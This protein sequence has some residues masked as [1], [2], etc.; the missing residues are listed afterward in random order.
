MQRFFPS[1]SPS[2]FVIFL[3]RLKLMYSP[4]KWTGLKCSTQSFIFIQKRERERVNLKSTGVHYSLLQICFKLYQQQEERDSGAAVKYKRKLL[5]S[6]TLK[7][8]GIVVERCWD[9]RPVQL[10]YN[11][12]KV[13]RWQT[14][15]DCWQMHWCHCCHARMEKTCVK[16]SVWTPSKESLSFFS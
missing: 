3:A 6:F 11:G 13:Q 10:V 7:N 4:S 5:S 2:T 15:W 8:L 14:V 16:V 12:P 1:L 9:C